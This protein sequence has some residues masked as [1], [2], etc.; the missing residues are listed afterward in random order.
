MYLKVEVQ[1]KCIDAFTTWKN[2]NKQSN[3]QYAI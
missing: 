1:A 3:M 2:K